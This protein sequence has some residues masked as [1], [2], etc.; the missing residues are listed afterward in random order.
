MGLLP[1]EEPAQP[2]HVC[3]TGFRSGRALHYFSGQH[4]DRVRAP[5][6]GGSLSGETMPSSSPLGVGVGLVGIG[7]S[8]GYWIVS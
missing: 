1:Y 4:H 2:H 3:S 6:K 5:P 8:V 7:S